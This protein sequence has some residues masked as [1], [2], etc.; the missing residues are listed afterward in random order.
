MIWTDPEKG[1]QQQSKMAPQRLIVS[2]EGRVGGQDRGSPI[3]GENEEKR[4]GH[5]K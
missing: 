3:G 1:K 5:K 2:E 4:K